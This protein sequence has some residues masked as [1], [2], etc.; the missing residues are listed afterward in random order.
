MSA[1]NYDNS[2]FIIGNRRMAEGIDKVSDDTQE[3][4]QIL[5]SQNQIA[6][7]RMTELSRVIKQSIHQQNSQARVN[8]T[9]NL[10]AQRAAN[11]AGMNTS[12][13]V[14]SQ[15]NR[16][17]GNRSSRLAANANGNSDSTSQPRDRRLT[18]Q[19]GNNSSVRARDANG[20][21]IPSGGNADSDSESGDSASNAAT[22]RRERA[23][24]GRFT[25][26]GST[27]SGFS[28][29]SSEIKSLGGG[30]LGGGGSVD[31]IL[32]SLKEA[33]DLLSPVGRGLKLAGKG[34]KL[35]FSKLKA[36]KRREPVPLQQDRHNRENE[37]LL[38]RIW[39]AIKKQGNGAGGAGLLG[40]LIGG[41]GGRGGMLKKAAKLLKGKAGLIGA[42]AG[43][44][45]LAS[46]WGES[47]DEEKSAGFGGLAGGLAGAGTGA[48]MGAAAGSVV[49][50]VGT[51]AGGL[52]GGLVGGWLGMGAGEALGAAVTPYVS[53]WSDSLSG[54]GL[55]EKMK[56][57][58]DKGLA[59]IFSSFAKTAGTMGSA[60]T[61]LWDKIKNFSAMFA[62]V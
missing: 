14:N 27:Q 56:S 11:D 10:S 20:R 52:V 54:Y 21:F 26:D 17:T 7:T 38:D 60:A 48:A 53:K 57:S 5:K 36:L 61:S 28:R 22:Q 42:V 25:S 4:V 12:Q 41:A 18:G 19:A 43:A 16:I 2:G 62:N 31:P 6:N 13:P 35:S 34:V 50:V 55:A 33:K 3:I 44:G 23:A 59:P 40:S 32:D 49:P 47:S 24:N 37:K 45:L 8:T 46:N 30:A 1:L 51:I 9:R 39:K 15:S 58:W 29:L